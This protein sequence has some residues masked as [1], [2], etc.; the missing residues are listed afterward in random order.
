MNSIEITINRCVDCGGLIRPSQNRC[1]AC[2]DRL[3]KDPETVIFMTVMEIVKEKVIVF[4]TVMQNRISMIKEDIITAVTEETLRFQQ[5]LNESITKI[6]SFVEQLQNIENEELP[7][8]MIE[9]ITS[10]QDIIS[11]LGIP[12]LHISMDSDEVQ[13]GFRKALSGEFIFFREII[14]RNSNNENL[15]S[16]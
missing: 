10:R 4:N 8:D 5:L 15:D 12:E 6:D 9:Q 13:D 7:H 2:L 14:R 1:Q 11:M 3:Q 16:E